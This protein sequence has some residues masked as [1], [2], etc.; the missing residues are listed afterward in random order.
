[1]ASACFPAYALA[2]MLV[3]RALGALRAVATVRIPAMAYSRLLITEPLAYP[4]A[5]LTFFLV[6]KALSTWRRP[7]LAAAVVS[8]CRRDARARP[9]A[10]ADPGRAR[11]GSV[12]LWL[13]D[14]APEDA[15]SV[16]AAGLGRSRGSSGCCVLV[17]AARAR[18]ARLVLLLPRHDAGRADARVRRLG[19]RCARRSGSRVFPVI[20]ALT[21][22]WRPAGRAHEPRVPRVRRPSSSGACP[23]SCSTRR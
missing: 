11:R 22:L 12:A 3:P 10:R 17:G 4:V 5:A 6:A 15:R 18:E 9:V 1:M 19:R 13:G 16:G 20:A 23:R 21:A 2:R 8:L 14:R 7:W